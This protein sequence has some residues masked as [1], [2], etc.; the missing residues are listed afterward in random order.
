MA[1]NKKLQYFSYIIIVLLLAFN[2]FQY[3]LYQDK[4][5]DLNLKITQLQDSLENQNNEFSNQSERIDNIEKRIDKLEY[6]VDKV[7]DFLTSYRFYG[8]YK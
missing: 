4:F 2:I 3:L 1:L 8:Y 6:V 7:T 5:E